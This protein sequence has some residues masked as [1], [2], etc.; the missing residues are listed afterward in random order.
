MTSNVI[1]I[2]ICHFPSCAISSRGAKVVGG[3]AT[4][5]PPLILEWGG[6]DMSLCVAM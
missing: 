1:P 2:I 3:V 6:I 5:P 4:P